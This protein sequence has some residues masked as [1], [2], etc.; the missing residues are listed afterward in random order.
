MELLTPPFPCRKR[1]TARKHATAAAHY[2][3]V[4]L[5]RSFVNL[6]KYGASWRVQSPL[7]PVPSLPPPS[8]PYDRS[9]LSR[10]LTPSAASFALDGS[11]SVDVDR[12][13]FV[14]LSPSQPLLRLRK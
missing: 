7:S 10:V 6:A 8:P 14:Y 4:L 9:P 1:F 12:D 3:K 11:L 13:G 5:A 2:K